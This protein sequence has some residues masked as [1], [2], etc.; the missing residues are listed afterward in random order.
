MPNTYKGKQHIIQRLGQNRDR[1]VG[2]HGCS[3]PWTIQ[4]RLYTWPAHVPCALSGFE[5]E[6]YG[7]LEL[8]SACREPASYKVVSHQTAR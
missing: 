5:A 4:I 3:F 2:Y 6:P 8:R 7:T 1:R